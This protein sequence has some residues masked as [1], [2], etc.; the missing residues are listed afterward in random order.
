[1]AAPASSDREMLGESTHEDQRQELRPRQR[2]L[3]IEKTGTKSASGA[4]WLACWSGNRAGT[5][6][7]GKTKNELPKRE[8]HAWTATEWE[9]GESDHR[10]R[11]RKLAATRN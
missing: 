8:L 9:P 1:L 11:E 10:E 4:E 3:W 7:S 6:S 5:E 2:N